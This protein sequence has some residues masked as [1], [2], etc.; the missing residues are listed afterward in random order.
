MKLKLFGGREGLL[1]MWFLGGLP[2][3]VGH[4]LRGAD[5]AARGCPSGWVGVVT[6]VCWIQQ[7]HVPNRIMSLHLPGLGTERD[8]D[9]S[10]EVEIRIKFHWKKKKAGGGRLQPQ[11]HLLG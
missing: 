5:T 1:L 4:V 2:E 7:L 6:A 3:Q 11:L 8:V 9:L 10:P